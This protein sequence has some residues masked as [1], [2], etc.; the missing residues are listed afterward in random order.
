VTL[1]APPSSVA[2]VVDRLGE[3]LA[4]WTV[5]G[6]ELAVV[7]HGESVFAGGFGL[8]NVESR[9]PVTPSTYFDH[10]SCGKAFTSLV[11]VLLA[12]D[13]VIDLDVPVRTYVP[14]LRLPDS[15]IAERVTIRDLL[16][17]RS[18]LDRHDLAWIYNPSWS[19]L[20]C[21]RRLEHLSLVGDLRAQWSYS[22]FGYTLAG[23]AMERATGSPF[24]ELIEKRVLHAAGMT[25]STTSID[26]V[27]ADADHATPYRVVDGI[28]I[29]TVRRRM[30]A[31]SPAGGVRPCP[32]EPTPLLLFQL[33][34]GAIAADVVR[35]TQQPQVAILDMPHPFPEIR[36][37]GY[38]L[39]WVVATYRGRH[40]LWHTGGVD[41]FFTYTLLLPDE[42]IGATSCANRLDTALPQAV[43][44]DVVDALLGERSEQT[45]AERMRV[46]AVAPEPPAPREGEPASPA[47]ALDAYVGRFSNGGYGDLV[48]QL[49]GGELLIS[50]GE[51]EQATRH[52]HFDTWDIHY[53]ALDGRGT[54]AFFTD[55][56]GGV[57][58]ALVTFE[59]APAPVRYTRVHEEA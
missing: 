27:E 58:E 51:F 5:P 3:E 23:L 50:V 46:G 11:A 55:A 56:D 34:Q 6:L 40:A 21:V 15:V 30:P 29:P 41:G 43:V 7:H 28:P 10:G 13:G 16:C 8:A 17:H 22:N 52:R 57:S 14:E 44:H 33:G 53:V 42:G 1:T 2:T 26:L 36:L 25:R 19:R 20:E 59:Q 12:E 31:T 9:A 18:G 45:W 37:Y 4:R 39:G 35:R 32:G 24:E 54:V 47:H 48:V 49:V 38:G